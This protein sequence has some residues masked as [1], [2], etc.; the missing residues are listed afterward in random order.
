MVTF[1][2]P[3]CEMKFF[4][5]YKDEQEYEDIET[6]LGN[7]AQKIIESDTGKEGYYNRTFTF[8]YLILNDDEAD[9]SKK[10]C[11]I[12]STGLE[13]SPS[14]GEWNLRAISLS[15][16]VPHRYTYTNKYPFIFYEY[17]VSDTDQR[18]SSL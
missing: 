10:F 13:L 18:G 16:G 6:S 14:L 7:S 9:Y 2:S 15:E 11:M 3:N 5:D 1:Y 12:Y 17:H 4:Y 8:Y